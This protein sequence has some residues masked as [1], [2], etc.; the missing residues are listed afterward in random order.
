MSGQLLRL[1]RCVCG[2]SPA[3]S[4]SRAGTRRLF[5][6]VCVRCWA[7]TATSDDDLAV[8][9]DWNDGE[10]T[11][12]GWEATVARAFPAMLPGESQL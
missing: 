8:I 6:I 10:L 1:N 5:A 9:G 3:I 7:R 2:A 11:A 12:P 4:I